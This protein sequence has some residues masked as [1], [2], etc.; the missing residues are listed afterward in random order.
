MHLHKLV[1]SMVT[2][3]CANA[4]ILDYAPKC[5]IAFDY[6]REAQ[7]VCE[8]L[9]PQLFNMPSWLWQWAV[10]ER[11]MFTVASKKRHWAG[12]QEQGR[13]YNRTGPKSQLW[14]GYSRLL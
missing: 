10:C 2:I 3:G 7:H 13:C 11:W 9:G 14:S 8:Q 1:L 12:K 4:L 6:Y 5:G